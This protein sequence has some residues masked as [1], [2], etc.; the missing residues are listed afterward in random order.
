MTLE[1]DAMSESLAP[2]AA[3]P[4]ALSATRPFYWSVR[5]ELWENRSVYIAPLA[6]AGVALLGFLFGMFRLP[7]AMR[8]LSA[9]QDAARAAGP[10]DV[11]AAKAAA[12][13]IHGLAMPY[14]FSAGVIILTGLIVAVFYCLGA[15]HGERRDRSIL[16]WKSLPVSDLTTVLSKATVPL[17][18]QPI[19]V[20]PI[21]L[22]VHLVMLLLSTLI[23]LSGG[24]DPAALWTNLPL[25]QMWLTMPYGLVVLALWYVPIA[26]WLLLVSAWARRVPMLWALAPPLGLCLFE[27]LAFHTRH[28][29]SLLIW[30]LTGGFDEAFTVGGLGK[31]PVSRLDQLDPLRFLANPG[32]WSGL[33][34]G[35]ACLAACVWLRRRRE[36]I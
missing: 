22:A 8:A 34:F 7:H 17:V 2:D 29:W 27:F 25:I 30:R 4:A 15:L 18:I 10:A 3:A 33:V 19:V 24:L 20:F 21:V 1:T 6:V 28:L 11:A 5:R 23:L 16:F 32:L 26:G 35:A 12:K 14:D 13:A 31:V 36:P 9:A